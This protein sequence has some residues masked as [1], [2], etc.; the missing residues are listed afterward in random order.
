MKLFDVIIVGGGPAGISAAC[1]S[2]ELG[3]SVLLIESGKEFG[4]QLLRTY[5]KITNHLGIET[6]NGREMRDVFVKQ[7]KNQEF[8]TR[9]NTSV[10]T[11]EFEAKYLTTTDGKTLYFNNLIIATGVSRRKLHVPGEREFAGKGILESGKRESE[12]V[13]GK[14]VC[15]IGGG[16][17]ALENALILA[18]C[19]AKVTLI[20][21]GETLRGRHEFINQISRNPKIEVLKNTQVLEIIGNEKLEAVKLQNS[22]EFLLPVDAT[23]IRIGVEPNT[24]LAREKIALDEAGY[25]KVT[26]FCETNLENI[27]AIGDVANS[28][29]PTISTAIGMGST[30]A[31]VIRDKT[32]I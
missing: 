7:M 25:V 27:Y 23:V 21:R 24:D 11:I 10:L 19:A 8:E 4:G 14:S 9:L 20:Y 18:E 30:A 1:W 13:S 15:V 17:A 6:N 22:A 32:A 3:L 26:Q 31:K 16:D 5:N 28:L 29:S 2:A 12:M